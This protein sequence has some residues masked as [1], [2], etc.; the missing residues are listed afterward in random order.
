MCDRNKFF[1]FLLCRGQYTYHENRIKI[2]R[3]YDTSLAMFTDRNEVKVP[4][5]D[6]TAALQCR[7]T[8][9]VI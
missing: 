5:Q 2:M 9:V 3:S 6:L 8:N 7:E 1:N 4:L